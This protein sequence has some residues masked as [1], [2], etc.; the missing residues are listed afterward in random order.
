[1]YLA[2][3]Q[4]RDSFSPLGEFELNKNLDTLFGAQPSNIF[5]LK[6]SYWLNP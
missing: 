1:M 2:W 6:I 5:L 3:Q 4:T